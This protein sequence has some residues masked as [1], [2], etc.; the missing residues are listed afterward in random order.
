MI[1][2]KLSYAQEI[3]GL[4]DVKP[5]ISFPLNVLPFLIIFAII[6]LALL[7]YFFHLW[8]K[9]KEKNKTRIIP[10]TPA[11]LTAYQRLDE[12]RKKDLVAKGRIKSYHSELS[13]IVRRYLED[14]LG[15]RAPE[16]TTEE[17]L[18]S[19]ER[20]KDLEDSHKK[21]LEGFLSLCDLVKF[22]KYG[23]SIKEGEA[24]FSLAKQ[25]IDETHRTEVERNSGI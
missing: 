7:V 11:Y 22:A 23:A 21:L 5:P 8:Q 9:K 19:L 4:R 1:F 20:S 13:D 15:L 6:F 16:M 2:S 25:F 24:G 14:E 17:F 18:F 3:E 10:K 12:L